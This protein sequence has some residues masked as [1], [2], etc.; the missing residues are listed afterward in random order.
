MIYNFFVYTQGHIIM[1]E[2]LYKLVLP[3][4]VQFFNFDANWLREMAKSICWH[5]GCSCFECISV[6]IGI[7]I[8]VK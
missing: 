8:D 1:L 2:L 4:T 3:V 5:R 7:T 6:C